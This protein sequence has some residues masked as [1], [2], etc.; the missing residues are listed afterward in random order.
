MTYI[1][2]SIIR[3]SSFSDVVAEAEARGWK[4]TFGDAVSGDWSSD[5]A[6]ACEAEAMMFLNELGYTVIVEDEGATE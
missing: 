5:E 1:A 3:C 6:D 4:D 2:H